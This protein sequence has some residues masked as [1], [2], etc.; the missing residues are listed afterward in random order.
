MKITTSLR[1]CCLFLFSLT[2]CHSGWTQCFPDLTPPVFTNCP[3]DVTILLDT[4]DCNRIYCYNLEATDNC[5]IPR[6]NLPGYQFIGSFNGNSYFISPPQLGTH[7][8]W[9]QANQ[10]AASLGGHLVTIESAAENS[11]LTANI[12]FANPLNPANGPGS[13][14]YWLGLRYSPMLNQ[15]KWITGEP[16]NYTNWGFGQPGIIPGEYIWFLDLLNVGTWWDSPSL[17]FRRFII[18][19]EGGLPIK[20]ISGIPSGNPFPPGQTTNVYQACDGSGNTTECSFTVTVIGSTSLSCK[21][22]NVSLDENCQALITPQMLLT[23]VYNCYDV[24]EVSLS[25]YGAPVPNPVDSNYLWKHLTATVYDPTTGNSCWS[26]VVIEDKLAPVIICR[27]DTVDCN[28]VDQA[29]PLDY[30]GFDC[31]R[32]SVKTIREDVEHLD[33]NRQYLKAIYRDIQITDVKGNSDYC[34]DTILV[35]RL[36]IDFFEFPVDLVELYCNR[37][38]ELDENG[39]PSPEVTGVPYHYQSDGTFNLI[40]PLNELLDC[41]ILVSYEDLDLGEINCVR[42]IMRTWTIREWWCNEEF[43][44]SYL[45]VIVIKDETGPE[46]TH[47][48]YGFDATT[49]KRDCKAR[50]LLP[51]IEAVDA[52]HND[53]RVDIAYPGGILID[54]NGGWVELPKGEDTVYYRV[55]D[56]CYNVTEVYIVVHVT[57]HTEP[58]AVCDRNTVVAITH[59]GYSWVNAEVFDDGSFDECAL[60]HFEVR[61]MDV[62]FCGGVGEDDWGAEVGFCCEDV[63]KM[64]MVGFKAIDHSGNEA[65]CMVNVE[66]QDKDRPLI[67]C[68]PNITV[69]CRFDIDHSHLEVFGKVVTEQSAREKIVID[70]RYWHQ[71]GGHPLDGLAEDNCPP[72]VIEEQDYGGLNQCGLGYIYR[73][74]TAVDQQGN[75]SQSCYQVITVTNHNVFDYNDIT[76]PYDYETSDICDPDQLIPERLNAPYDRPRTNDDE[77]SLIGMSYHDHV[78]SPTIPGDPCFKII[79]VW[80]VIDWCQRDLNNNVL[81]WQDTQYIKVFNRIDPTIIRVTQDTVVCSYDINCRPIPVSFSIE[82]DDDCTDPKQMLYTYKIDLDSDGT[83]DVTRSSIGGNVA[84]GTWKL[85]KHL[86]KWEVEDRCGNTVKASFTLDLQN[87]KPPVAYCLNGLSTNLVP[88][89]LDGDGIPDAAMDTIWAKDFDA[90][91]YHNCGYGVKFSFSSD[92]NETYRIY[93]CDDRGLQEV[94][95]WVTDE[96]GNTSF[97]RTFIDIQDNSGFCPPT[98]TNAKVEGEIMTEA[99]DR[100]E[101]VGVELEN[102]GRNEIMTNYDGRYAF[103]QLPSGTAYELKP[104]KTDGWLNGV[105]TAD[106]VK[107]QRHILGIEPITTG[108]RMI[109]ADVNRS[110]EITA[111]DVSELRRLILGIT[112]EIAGNTS[113]RFVSSRHVFNDVSNAL[114]ESIPESVEISNLYGDMKLDFYAVKVG[115]L[116]GTAA[117]KGYQGIHSRSDRILELEMEDRELEAGE[118]TEIEL[119][120]ANGSQYAGLQFTL[121]WLKEKMEIVRIEGNKESR[122]GEDSYATHSMMN[123]KLPLSWNGEMSDGME[124]I[125]LRVKARQQMRLSEVMRLGESITAAISVD[126]HGEEGKVVLRY[127]GTTSEVFVVTPNEPNPWNRETVIG[128]Y[129]QQAG[130][131]KLSI[132]DVNGRIHLIQNLN[133]TKGYHEYNINREHL[134]QAGVYYYQLDYKDAT[135]TGKMIVID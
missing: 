104:K 122:V 93:D 79:R 24:F 57:D 135:K 64:V 6:P 63:G 71:I 14:Q 42:K 45:Q 36:N 98:L 73:Y 119:K 85:G 44:R 128:I 10:L 40:W 52:C 87:C 112:G 114:K 74:F 13:N 118:E 17:L 130:E 4:F 22:I 133:L 18:E 89:D 95:M 56:A 102:S 129:L 111:K 8:H 125:K 12:P 46:I 16:V 83:I 55:Y 53:L 28:L 131:V 124:L 32:Y 65:I 69:D 60:H 94:E 91:S 132:Y 59:N 97:C 110:G 115:D 39:H 99:Q 81:I 134:D 113:W 21:N 105:S 100:V 34:T 106:I 67:S 107:I 48:P 68:P 120:I 49:G 82:A 47:M 23:G 19:F 62:D 50:V 109:A 103:E 127:N 37:Y 108:Y 2:F 33:C 3:A 72:E 25:Y 117:T 88:M 123:G 58:V 101:N 54:Q 126:K 38:F 20:L 90:G 80:K 7:V 26:D 30:E 31:S 29:Y 78:L 11:F 5:T 35:R 43:V 77:C 41:H 15:Y 1:H 96:N 9:L 75:R 27:A 61:R 51:P 121:E 66:V 92:T 84:S 86:V 76:W 70:P 116:N